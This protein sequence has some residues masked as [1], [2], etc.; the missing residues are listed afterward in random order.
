MEAARDA[1]GGACPAASAPRLAAGAQPLR[2]LEPVLLA[3]PLASLLA[4][5]ACSL[6]SRDGLVRDQRGKDGAG[7]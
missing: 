7:G 6:T 3:Q 5:P 2:S 1:A 4:R